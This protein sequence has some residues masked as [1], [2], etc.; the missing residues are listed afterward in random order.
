MLW[1]T[2]SL[3]SFKVS[4]LHIICGAHIWSILVLRLNSLTYLIIYQSLSV[5]ESTG[6]YSSPLLDVKVH[7]LVLEANKTLQLKC[8]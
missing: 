1:V 2:F 3:S 4:A 8:R 5:V 7:Q 6:K